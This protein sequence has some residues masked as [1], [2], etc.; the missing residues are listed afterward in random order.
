MAVSESRTKGAQTLARGLT[1]LKFVAASPEGVTIAEVAGFAQVHRSMAYRVLE[2]LLDAG[3]ISRGADSKYRGAAG[4]LELAAAGHAGL[5][6]AAREPLQSAADELGVTLALLVVEG[7][8][9]LREARA[10]LVCAPQTSHF[11]ITFREGSSHPLNQGAAGAALSAMIEDPNNLLAA[12]TTF[13]EVEPNMHGIAVPLILSPPQPLA[14]V[15][16]ISQRDD[17]TEPA[18]LRLQQVVEEIHSKSHEEN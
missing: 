16:A 2:T 11:H 12:Y 15:L 4:L 18:T 1:I 5:R 13:G 8:A 14:C 6:Q 3:L 9:G 17:L 7:H 10:V